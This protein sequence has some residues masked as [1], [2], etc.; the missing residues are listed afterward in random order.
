[1]GRQRRPLEREAPP[2]FRC[3]GASPGPPER[4]AGSRASP[5][6]RSL[7]A[8]LGGKRFPAPRGAAGGVFP[9]LAALERGVRLSPV[10]GQRP[11]GAWAV[12]EA[13]VL[14][15]PIPLGTGAVSAAIA[16]ASWLREM[17]WEFE[18]AL[19]RDWRLLLLLRGCL[20]HRERPA[21]LSFE[22]RF[23]LGFLLL[24]V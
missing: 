10:P 15:G 3:P 9:A 20:N 7:E 12:P 17:V 8:V 18:F 2:V 16:C 23:I 14:G 11:L 4:S 13:V 24:R 21:G 1:M 5:P 22:F 6:P 19:G